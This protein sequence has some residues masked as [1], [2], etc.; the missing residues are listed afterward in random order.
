MA[1]TLESSTLYTI[2]L[3]T[4][5]AVE[6][7]AV[8]AQIDEPHQEPSGFIQS[9][10]DHNSYTWGRIGKHNVVLVSLPAGDSGIA[11][12][13]STASL[14]QSSLPHIR[15]ALLVGIGGGIVRPQTSESSDIRLGDIVV[16]EPNGTSSGIV[17][18][19]R[20]KVH[21]N[22][23]F[24][25]TGSLNRPPP[26]LLS[27]LQVLQKNH[28]LGRSKIESLLKD[29]RNK[30]PTL[31]EL[32]KYQGTQYDRLFESAYLHTNGK[33]CKDCD[34]KHEIIRPARESDDPKI[35]YGSIASG[36]FLIRDA[37]TRDS[38]LEM[39]GDKLLC[40]EMEAAGLANQLGC[41]VIRGISDY[42]D[43]HK[44]DQWHFYAAATA[45]AF[46][47]DLLSYVNSGQQLAA[48]R[49]ISTLSC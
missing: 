4:T 49:M 25:R 43:S 14:L 12:A 34:P 16:S 31:R 26:I 29:M 24:E 39:S 17:Q 47:K 22:T 36:D 23:V 10:A 15:A 7:A 8:E 41:L 20:G 37:M 32:L 6:A 44:N 45:A 3:I 18:Y 42:S 11:A 1:K 48:T 5:L 33:T 30:Y 46:A 9:P 38:I 21:P 2:A 13:A 19:C 28:L 27:A 35:Y 40:F